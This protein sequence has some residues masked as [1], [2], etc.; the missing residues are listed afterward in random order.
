MSGIFKVDDH[1]WCGKTSGGIQLYFCAICPYNTHYKGNARTHKRVHTRER[2][3][4]CSLCEKSFTVKSNL[5]RHMNSSHA[6][7]KVEDYI[8][9]GRTS[10]G[11][12]VYFCGVCTYMTHSKGHARIHRR[13][14]TQEKPYQCTVCH[15]HFTQS[16]TLY[17]HLRAMMKLEDFIW[18]ARTPGGLQ[19]YFCSACPYKTGLKGHARTHKR[20]HTRE[21]PFQCSICQRGFTQSSN[22]YRHMKT[23]CYV[24]SYVWCGRTLFGQRV[25]FCPICPYETSKKSH[26]EYHSRKHTKEKPFQCPLCPKA[27]TQKFNTTEY[28]RFGVWKG[29]CR[30]TS[31]NIYFCVYCDYKT[32]RRDNALY[33]HSRAIFKVE[34]YI[35][36]GKTSG[37]IQ[38]YFCG[39]CSYMAFSKSHTR[40]HR[41]VHTQERPYQCTVCHKHFTQSSTLY[42]HLR[43][44]HRIH[45]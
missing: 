24:Q 7:F 32:P 20:V 34:D 28:V 45:Q 2:P 8:W 37:G 42:R 35:W 5:Y 31:R 27:F 11:I 9:G 10:G 12:Q 3:F 23:M 19:L 44:S 16:S 25:Y 21:R 43:L 6:I 30:S 38:V 29:V 22:L 15:K 41:R 13:V 33:Q 39:V 40:I 26:A 18:S 14:H 1:I 4:Q 17:R 36:S